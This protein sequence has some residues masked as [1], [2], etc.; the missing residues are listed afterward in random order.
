MSVAMHR[1][2]STHS[3]GVG[4]IAHDGSL[5][6]VQIVQDEG[7]APYTRRWSVRQ[8]GPGQ[9]TG[10]MSQA[11]G[12]VTIQQVGSRFRFRFMIKGALSVEEWLTPLA[13]GLLATNEVTV[14]KFGIPVAT[15]HGLVRKLPS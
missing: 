11:T 4:T 9:F 14:S 5:S 3:R 6:L 8:V 13:G 12:P 1:S 7:R 15:S 10:S 2:K